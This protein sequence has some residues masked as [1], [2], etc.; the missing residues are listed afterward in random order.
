MRREGLTAREE[1]VAA[2]LLEGL[3]NQQIATR[4]SIS[5]NTVKR[6]VSAMLKKTGTQSRLELVARLRGKPEQ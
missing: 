6:H 5:L 4:L 1:E 3:S 2:L